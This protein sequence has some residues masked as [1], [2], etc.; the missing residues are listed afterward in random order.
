MYKSLLP[1]FR[2]KIQ[3]TRHR[4]WRANPTSCLI[5]GPT[6]P[7][8]L[9]CQSLMSKY[10]VLLY[11]IVWSPCWSNSCLSWSWSS[12]WKKKKRMLKRLQFYI[13]HFKWPSVSRSGN[14]SET[15]DL[16][17][18][19]A[20]GHGSFSP[21][22]DR[23]KSTHHT[24]THIHLH[25]P[26]NP[27]CSRWYNLERLKADFKPDPPPPP[28]CITANLADIWLSQPGFEPSSF[29]RISQGLSPNQ[30]ASQ[31]SCLSS[32]TSYST[33]L[34]HSARRWF[35]CNNLPSAVL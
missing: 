15:L 35:C 24:Y 28:Q 14:N 8:W 5:S 27:T 10:S 6:F 29:I 11:G 30:L 32:S 21:K 2:D 20:A 4:S 12:A 34:L 3:T 17:C 1:C 23:S 13:S 33:I 16:L 26:L 25:A 18:S 9:K 22:Q 31:V 19:Q 7:I